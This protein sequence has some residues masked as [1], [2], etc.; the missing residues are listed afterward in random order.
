MYVYSA[1][2]VLSYAWSKKQFLSM[3]FGLLMERL[4]QNIGMNRKLSFSCIT[5]WE[6]E[7]LTSIADRQVL[8]SIEGVLTYATQVDK[9]IL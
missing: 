8:V 9:Q 5:G 2:L 7:D 3:A 6:A 4:K 1:P